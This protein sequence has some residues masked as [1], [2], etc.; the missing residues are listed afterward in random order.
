MV[1]WIDFLK[2]GQKHR[3]PDFT[4]IKNELLKQESWIKEIHK[5]SKNLHNFANY[6]HES[7]IKHKKEMLD[8]ITGLVKWVDYL[9]N[10]HTT[11]KQ[12]LHDLRHGLRKSLRSD[13]EIYHNTLE[14][15]IKVRLNEVRLNKEEIKKELLEELKSAHTAEKQAFSGSQ[16]PNPARDITHYNAEIELSNPE[17]L[18]LNVLF[19]ENK[20]LTYEDLSRKT[21][22]SVSSV[23]VYMNSLKSKKPIIEDFLTP[24]GAKIFSV[25]NSEIVKTLF[26][27]KQI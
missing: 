27:I 3:Q 12:E 4:P 5:N 8:Q 26:N 10:N 9:N 22:K 21:G 14:E 11:L 2:N 7:N 15:Y 16:T 1:R 20:P 6:I 24:T 18:L 23:R 13:F 19:N 17:K 25:K